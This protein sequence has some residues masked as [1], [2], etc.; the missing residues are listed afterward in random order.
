MSNTRLTFVI[1]D[2]HG[3]GEALT[4][5]LTAIDDYLRDV[6]HEDYKIIFLGDYID[7]G[8]DSKNVVETIRQLQ[9]TAPDKI[10]TLK[11]NH[12]L[13]YLEALNGGYSDK[14]LFRY[15]GGDAT[16][17]SYGVESEADI[18]FTHKQFFRETRYSYQD[19]LRYFVHAGIK[20]RL[21][22]DMQTNHDRVWIRE[23][24]LA[25]PGP[26]PKYIV[27]GHTPRKWDN[28]HDMTSKIRLNLDF[29]AV[30]GGYL[31]CAVFNDTEV[32]P[33]NYIK[34]GPLSRPRPL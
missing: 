9:L 2:I 19:D 6:P 32:E 16:L 33:I 24:F 13:M 17:K 22:L 11:G 8:P 5:I 7:R 21:P 23:E 1:G 3:M 14:E 12:E 10:I 29:G 30:Y 34:C 20:P 26:F 18:P 27:H 4:S 15:N 31:V 28:Y 25:S